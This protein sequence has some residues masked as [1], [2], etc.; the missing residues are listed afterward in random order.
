MAP[1]TE[2]SYEERQK[3]L[4]LE[5]AS[6]EGQTKISYACAKSKILVLFKIS[7]AR[8]ASISP[9]HWKKSLLEENLVL[10]WTLAAGF[11]PRLNLYKGGTHLCC[12][13]CLPSAQVLPCF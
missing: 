5:L 7:V 11:D 13:S 6:G 8:P 2:F 1:A 3:V 9:L 10:Q 4:L 12:S